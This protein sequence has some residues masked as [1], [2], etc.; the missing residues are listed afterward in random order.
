MNAWCSIQDIIKT[1][2]VEASLAFISDT[3]NTAKR[4]ADDGKPRMIKIKR[5][6]AHR[7]LPTNATEASMVGS[8]E[9]EAGI[10]QL[11]PRRRWVGV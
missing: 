6:E 1:F 8:E 4:H 9:L 3:T 5:R 10:T 2:A 11:V 7:G